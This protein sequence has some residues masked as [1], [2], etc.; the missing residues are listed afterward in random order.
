[1]SDHI[2]A[3]SC[4]NAQQLAYSIMCSIIKPKNENRL[5]YDYLD[6]LFN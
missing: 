4:E 2:T 3:V 6:Y 1:M 5:E